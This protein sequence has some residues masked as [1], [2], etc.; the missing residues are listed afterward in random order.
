MKITIFNGSPWIQQSHT[1][2]MIEDLALGAH[3]AGAKIHNITLANKRIEPCNGCE[4]CFYKTPGKC[5]IKDDMEDLIHHFADS[6]YVVFATP[7]YME[8]VTSLMKTFIDRLMPVLEPHYEED[9]NGRLR[10]SLRLKRSPKF[11]IL[12]GC[13]IPEQSEF[14][15][16]KGFFNRLARTLYTEIAG[17]IYRDAVGL[18]LLHD[19]VRFSGAVNRFRTLLRSAGTELVR[20]GFISHETT[21]QLSLPLVRRE[22]YLEYANHIWDTLA[23]KH[24]NILSLHA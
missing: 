2:F 1:Q 16:I 9:A 4:Q 6:H 12:S 15:V 8:N 7:V 10:R 11:V 20:N 17:E 24:H 13:N 3:K 14:D 23:P 18:L 19:E 5:R 21:R 22:D